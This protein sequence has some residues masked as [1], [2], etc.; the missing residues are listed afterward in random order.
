[1]SQPVRTRARGAA[2]WTGPGMSL[3][4]ALALTAA[5]SHKPEPTALPLVDRFSE[6][7]VENTLAA[8]EEPPRIVWLFEGEPGE[9]GPAMDSPRRGSTAIHDVVS[10][11]ASRSWGSPTRR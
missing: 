4:L 3:T 5:C 8:E 2:P 9:T 1:M 7:R 11:S 10:S 6:A